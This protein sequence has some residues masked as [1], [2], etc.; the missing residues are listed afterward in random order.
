MDIILRNGSP[1]DAETCGSICYNAF[2]SI[3][4]QHNFA[5]DFPALDMAIRL[6]SHLFSRPEVHSVMAEVDGRVVGSNF[7]WENST[8]A[9][10]GPITV[11]PAVQNGTV[12]RHLMDHVLGR[13]QEIRFGGIRL[14]QAA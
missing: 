9:G 8:I 11:D 10:V 6:C 3:A 5:P 13:A 7:L 14:V 4:E 1:S 12:G 2:K